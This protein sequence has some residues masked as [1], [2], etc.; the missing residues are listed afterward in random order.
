M[1][2][3]L[4]I[5]IATVRTVAEGWEK[6]AKERRRIS[7]TDPVADALD[8]CASEVMG[9]LR[10]IE[11]SSRY[12]TTDEYAAA[13]GVDVQTVRRWIRAGKLAAIRAPR[14]YMIRHDSKPRQ[15]RAA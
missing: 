6:E 13:V 14:G 12:L 9:E 15:E 1:T 5:A 10:D 3:P 7:A 4:D 2:L 8:Y 11:R